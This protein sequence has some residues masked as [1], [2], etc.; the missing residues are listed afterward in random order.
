MYLSCAVKNR[1]LPGL[2]A[3]FGRLAAG[4]ALQA[5]IAGESGTLEQKRHPDQTRD[6]AAQA[7]EA[8]LAVAHGEDL[9]EHA[10]PAAGREKGKQALEDKQAGQREPERAAVQEIYFLGAVPAPEPRMALK[11]SDEGSTT[12]TSLFFAKLAL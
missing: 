9:L 1:I 3:V 2:G 8:D 10:A 4:C 6:D 7:E 5:E 12:I 11:K